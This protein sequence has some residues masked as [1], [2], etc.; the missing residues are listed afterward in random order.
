MSQTRRGRLHAVVEEQLQQRHH[1]ERVGVQEWADEDERRFRIVSDTRR[2]W[3]HARRG[4][5]SLHLVQNVAH[6]DERTRADHDG[7]RVEIEHGRLR[8]RQATRLRN[9]DA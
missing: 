5:H 4:S 9:R 2:V 3:R 6:L 1:K 8:E 7:R